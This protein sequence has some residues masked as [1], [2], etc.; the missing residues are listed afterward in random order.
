VVWKEGQPEDA[1]AVPHLPLPGSQA[2]ALVN[3][4]VRII[5]E[6]GDGKD[7][8][9]LFRQS[10]GQLVGFWNRLRRIVLGED[11][12]TRIAAPIVKP[13]DQLMLPYIGTKRQEHNS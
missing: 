2:I 5:R 10:D 11:Q 13:V 9:A 8:M 4:A 6:C 3:G 1:N 12:D 7:L